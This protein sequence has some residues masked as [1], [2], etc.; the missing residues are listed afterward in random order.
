MKRSV[1]SINNNRDVS[2]SQSKHIQPNTPVPVEENLID[3]VN[4]D[5]TSSQS[6]KKVVKVKSQNLQDKVFNDK[7]N[8]DNNNSII[9]ASTPSGSSISFSSSSS[10][11]TNDNKR[12]RH[13]SDMFTHSQEK[14][15]LAISHVANVSVR[16]E[17]K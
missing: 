1:S 2:S 5:S 8:H 16:S 11:A 6:Q 17:K 4:N 15:P 13:K 7:L 14:T 9:T 10:S 3:H 12:T